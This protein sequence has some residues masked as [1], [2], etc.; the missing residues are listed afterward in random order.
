MSNYT[1]SEGDNKKVYNIKETKTEQVI[2]SF[3]NFNEA[4]KYMVYLNK[5]GA[6]DG[7]TPNFFLK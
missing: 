3:D 1:I 6:F 7:W 4:R 2:R 5:G